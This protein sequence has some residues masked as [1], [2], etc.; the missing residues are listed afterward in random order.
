M[1]PAPGE[2]AAGLSAVAS[3]WPPLQKAQATRFGRIHK[4][5]SPPVRRVYGHGKHGH[6]HSGFKRWSHLEPQLCDTSGELQEQGPIRE[7]PRGQD[8]GIEPQ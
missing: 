8:T 6:L 3:R 1:L 2:A 5:L 7:P 4:A